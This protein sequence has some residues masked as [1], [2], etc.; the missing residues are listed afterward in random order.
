MFMLFLFKYLEEMIWASTILCQIFLVTN[1]I[2]FNRHKY[3]QIFCFFKGWNNFLLIL[4]TF[5]FHKVQLIWIFSHLL[6]QICFEYYLLSVKGCKNQIWVL[7]FFFFL[8]SLL[9]L[10]FSRLL[11]LFSRFCSFVNIIGFDFY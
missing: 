11:L 5:I 3:F 2:Y 9:N 7:M 1:W 10:F 4:G 8:M 6:V